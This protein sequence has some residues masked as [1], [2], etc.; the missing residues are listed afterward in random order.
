M[1]TIFKTSVVLV[2]LSVFGLSAQAQE[3][4]T[5]AKPLYKITPADAKAINNG[6]EK[7]RLPMEKKSIYS[8]TPDL[9]NN[10]ATISTIDEKGIISKQ[11]V[12]LKEA[13]K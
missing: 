11:K 8:C 7:P 1:K 3:N 9:K 4:K 10:T 5:E 12:E 13:K 2:A 6:L